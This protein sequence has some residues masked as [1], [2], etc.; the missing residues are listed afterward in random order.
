MKWLNLKCE[1][2]GL[3]LINGNPV[4]EADEKGLT[5]PILHNQK[6]YISYFPLQDS[7]YFNILPL[8]RLVEFS[9]KIE[10]TPDGSIQI[11]S[12][13]NGIVQLT[14]YPPK[15]PKILPEGITSSVFN[16][17]EFYLDQRHL[18]AYVY[19]D[20]CGYLTVEEITKK[21]TVF[22]SPLPEF[23]GITDT[24]IKKIDGLSVLC[25]EGVNGAEKL[26]AFYALRP[27][28][29]EII[30][31]LC[32]DYEIEESAIKI[33]AK[34]DIDG[35]YDIYNY[36]R[37]ENTLEFTHLTS[38]YS[39]NDPEL[40]CIFGMLCAAAANQD[41]SQ[42]L[43]ASLQRELSVKEIK[44]FLED[45][46]GFYLPHDGAKNDIA[47][48]YQIST[49]LYEARTFRFKLVGGKIDNIIEQ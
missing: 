30:C 44:D 39:G 48:K 28:L 16:G 33:S 1:I 37:K 6:T 5:L 8:C 13:N 19:K 20:I 14:L 35:L 43:T 11:V 34:S 42:Y 12:F 2:R 23:T 36:A 49:N 3:I 45:F 25:V 46:C 41:F 4:G 22:L 29:K 18:Y 27:N 32:S 40:R 21:Q 24:S 31:V 10:F 38:S 17:I 7:K 47:L 9:D 15:I 26:V